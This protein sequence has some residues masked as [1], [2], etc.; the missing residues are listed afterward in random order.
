MLD[1]LREEF[2]F[3]G[4]NVFVLLVSWVLMNFAGHMPETYYSL[5]VLGLGGTAF[6]VGVISLAYMAALASV[7]F[8]GGYLAD[9]YGRKRL[10]VTMTFALAVSYLLYALAPTWKLI[11]VGAVLQGLFLVYQP[12]LWAILADSLPSGKRGL[13]FALSYVVGAVSIASP[14]VAGYLVKRMG[15][16]LGMRIAYLATVAAYLTA[17]A[18]RLRLRETLKPEAERPSILELVKS[19]PKAIGESF[20]VL[21]ALPRPVL[22]LTTIYIVNYYFLY[23][24]WQYYVIYA[25]K[26]LGVSEAFW[27]LLSAVWLASMYTSSM[28]SGKLVDVVGRV[29]PLIASMPMTAVATWM[30]IRGGS[31]MLLSSFVVDGV[32]VSLYSNAFSA[33]QTDLVPTEYRGRVI[34]FTNFFAYV[35]GAFGGFAGGYLYEHVSPRL[36]FTLLMLVQVPLA[37]SS[38]VL[39][40]EPE[41]R[42]G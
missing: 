4:G 17:A 19:Y 15:L 26:V 13:G 1:R 39:L 2:S 22:T 35:A 7:Q 18:F 38:A 42:E 14:V 12:A 37:V 36:P 16:L 20:T 24:C 28:P 6:T 9:S 23:M 31:V 32:A 34:G 8:L 30:F 33:L 25:T 11:L 3:V 21:G 10:I 41:V 29:G 27:A 40:K 5:Y